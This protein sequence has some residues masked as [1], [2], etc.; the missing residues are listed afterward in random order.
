MRYDRNYTRDRHERVNRERDEKA[1]TIGELCQVIAQRRIPSL[2]QGDE[3][4]V[5]VADV[6]GL[7]ALRERLVDEDDDLEMAPDHEPSS[8]E[9]GRP[10]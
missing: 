10:A 2:R 8:L 7:S 4:I 9:V 1:L 5:R 6:R 3:Y